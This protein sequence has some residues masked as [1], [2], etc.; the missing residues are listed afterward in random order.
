MQ[1]LFSFSVLPLI[2]F[3]DGKNKEELYR[4]YSTT[5]TTL[6]KIC[7]QVQV[8]SL[9]IGPFNFLIKKYVHIS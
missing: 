5:P 2:I 1:F 3:P 7:V 4:I 8:T 6:K 9:I